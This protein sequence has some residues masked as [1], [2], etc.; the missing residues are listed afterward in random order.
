VALFVLLPTA[1]EAQTIDRKF[2]EFG[3]QR[4]RVRE[5]TRD[6]CSRECRITVT[7]TTD[8]NVIITPG[9]T[10]F[11]QIS[12]S[13]GYNLQG[14]WYWKCCQTE[15]RSRINGA[16]YIKAIRNADT[17]A[18]EWYSVDPPKRGEGIAGAPQTIDQKFKN[19]RQGSI[20]VLE[21][22]RD[23]CDRGSDIMVTSTIDGSVIIRPGETRYFQI[24]ELDSYTF[25]GGWYWQCEE[26]FYLY[27]KEERSRIKGARYIKAVRNADTGAIDWYSVEPLDAGALF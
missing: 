15:E 20:R 8:G 12:E 9:E 17:G 7:S 18:I 2:K 24:K 14:G 5:H 4:I 13:D 25:G 26:A 21:H 11:F 3:E 16:R 6:A 23:A 19:L 1:S 22:T 27:Q 10:K